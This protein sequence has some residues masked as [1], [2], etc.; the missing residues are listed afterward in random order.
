MQA[1]R[2]RCW[3]TG[4]RV[5][6]GLVMAFLLVVGSV[7]GASPA[8]AD[9]TTVSYDNNR[10]GWDPNQPGLGPSDVTAADFGQL[11]ATQLDGQIYA[12]P[13]IARDTL[14]AVTENNKAYGLDPVT[15]AIRWSR[16]VGKPWPAS[17]I[18][19]GDLVPNIGITATPVVDPATGTAYFTSKVDDGPTAD[20]PSWYMHGVDIA[21]GQE[22]AGFPTKI[23][24]RPTNN[25]TNSFNARTAMQRPGLLLLDGVVYAAFASHCDLGDYVGYVI[26]FDAGSGRQTTMWATETGSAS[27]KAGIWHSGGGLVSDGPGR[28]FFTTGNGVSPPPGPGTS[29]PGTL[30]EAVVRL[31]VNSDRSLV[32]KDFFSPVNNT[33]LDRDDTDFGSGAPMVIPEGFG[34]AQHP[35][36]MVQVGKDGRVYLLDRDNLGGMGQGPNR[37]DGVLQIGGPY[38]GVWGHPAFWGGDGGYVYMVTNGGPLSAFKIGVAG[39]GLPALTRTGTSSGNFGYSSG[40]PAVTSDGTKSGTAL[41]WAV[42]ASGSNGSGGQIRAYEALPQNGQMVLRY[43]APIGTATKFAKPATDKG[44]V[45]TGTRDGVVFGFGRPTTVALSGSPTDFGGVPVGSTVNR[46]VTVTAVTD[47]T[48]TGVTTSGDG[49]AV[50]TVPVPSRLAK[51]Q[52]LS[53]PVSFTPGS[54]VSL[55]GALKFATSAGPLGFDLRG[56][57]TRD[58]LLSTPAALDFEEVPTGGLVTL[59]INITNTGT[60]P[61]TVTGVDLP[62]GSYQVAAPPAVGSTIAAGG[63]VAIPITFAPTAAGAQPATLRVR[64]STGA[65]SVPLTGVGVVGVAKLVLTPTELDFGN[66]PIGQTVTK[67]FD[68]TNQGNLSL[69]LSKAAPPAAPFEVPDPVAEGQELEPQDTIRQVVS[70]TPTASGQI[71]GSYVINGNDGQGAQEVRVRG[72]G[73]SRAFGAV[74]GSGGKCLDVRYGNRANGTPVQIWDCNGSAPQ[75]WTVDQD[76]NLRALGSCLDVAG[77]GPANGTPVQLWACNDSPAQE[78]VAQPDGSLRNPQSGKCLDIPSND[79]TNGRQLQIWE[80]NGSAPQKWNVPI[81]TV[82]SGPVVGPTG[83]CLDVRQGGTANGTPVQLFS[84]NGT[85]PQLWSVGSDRTVRALDKCLDVSAGGFVNGAAVQLWECNGTDAQDWVQQGRS[86]LNPRSGRCVDVPG[87]QYYDGIALQ[88]WQCNGTRPQN[89]SLPVAA[90]SVGPIVGLAGKCVDIRSGQAEDG[91]PVQLWACNG[92][93]PQTWSLSSDRTIR[94]LGKCLDVVPGESGNGAPVE[95]TS[96]DG[97]GSQLW[98][99]QG[100]AVRNLV[101]GRCLDVPGGNTANGVRLQLWACNGTAPQQWLTP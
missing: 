3:P 38:N 96:C 43:S 72:T 81:T 19:C 101:S 55:T 6:T 97:S 86:L 10:T 17:N 62:G 92:S 36:L 98:I 26:G 64:S 2:G 83:R 54:P 41:V 11:F 58:G 63:S 4:R 35:R 53:V 85:A 50:G 73:I 27:A 80:C 29:P 23:A 24:G 68:I 67:T 60:T 7:T 18:G 37:T 1:T 75:Q 31:Q 95:L 9:N 87:G 77:G 14:L 12:Q 32:S 39:D 15:G 66:V 76:R 49:F 8:S 65:V 84:C 22:R 45:Y 46:S 57:G 16:D 100:D 71:N 94:G 13:V 33:K 79:T 30:G 88:V 89:W 91:T 40:S 90:I 28:I 42:Y 70:F 20:Q 93:E 56:I 48:V 82:A 69:V 21:T 59:S 51:G 5:W 25:P 47:V 78:W 74:T 52:S 34:T 44:R 99:Q 61:T